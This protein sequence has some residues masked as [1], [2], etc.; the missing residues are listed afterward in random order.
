[1]PVKTALETIGPKEAERYLSRNVHNRP[2]RSRAVEKF[3]ATMKEGRWQL[4]HQG[5]AMSESNV[6]LDGQHKLAAILRAGVSVPMF[7][8]TGLPDST[9]SVID[10]GTRRT[11]SDTLQ[12]AGFPNY[13]NL[14]AALRVLYIFEQMPDTL[15]WQ[16]GKTVVSNDVILDMAEKHSEADEWILAG[17]RVSKAIHTP[18]AAMCGALL[19]LAQFAPPKKVHEFAKGLAEGENLAAGNPILV[20]RNWLLRRRLLAAGRRGAEYDMRTSVGI[21]VK[22]WNRWNE[23]ETVQKI[24]FAYNEPFPIPVRVL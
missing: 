8:T 14:A 15:M 22:A 24:R 4:T 12:T 20:C 16:G 17:M 7:V 9:F 6:L 23:G 21:L 2:L 19:I 13:S 11:V 10:V 1:M 18:P 5:V 3:A